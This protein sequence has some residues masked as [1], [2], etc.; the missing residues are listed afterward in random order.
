VTAPARSINL[1]ESLCAEAERQFG[2]RFQN[3]EELLAFV[4][5]ELT[6]NDSARLDESEEKMLEYRLKELGYL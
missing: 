6:R 1:P 5:Q 3:V 4:L 2:A